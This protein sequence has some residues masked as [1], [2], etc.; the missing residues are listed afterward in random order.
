M[1]TKMIKFDLSMKGVKVTNFEELQEHFSADIL[2]IF[3]TGR[4][5]KWLMSRELVAQAEAIVAIDKNSTELQQ[6]VAISRVLELDDDEEVLQ[7]LLDDRQAAQTTSL[8]PTTETDADVDTEVETQIES[9]NVQPIESQV[10]ILEAK[11]ESL[12]SML[13]EY[14]SDFRR[15]RSCGLYFGSDLLDEKGRK[16][17]EG[18]ERSYANRGKGGLILLYDSTIFGTGKEGFYLTN[19]EF[20]I[21]FLLED[22]YVVSIRNINKFR[23]DKHDCEFSIN[24]G[25]TYTYASSTLRDSLIIISK[26][27]EKYNKQFSLLV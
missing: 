20:F 1:A 16:K 14:E 23:V 10:V 4:L 17:V 13:N 19:E 6:L 11:I 15:A 7:F 24:Y 21:K 8:P 9:N 25:I 26:C 18:A 27:I 22:R 2:P 3:Q 5:A 12:E